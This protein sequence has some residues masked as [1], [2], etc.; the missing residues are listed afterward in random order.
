MILGMM[1][2]HAKSWLIKFLIGIIAVVFIFYFGYSFTAKQGLKVALV[3]GE[4]IS[5]LEYGK[6]YNDLLEGLRRQYKDI[7]SDNLI[8]V[9]DLKRRALDNL[10][11]QKL[12]S[13]EAR[14][15]GLDVTE[16][17]VQKAIMDYPAFQ[18]DGRFVMG[19]YKS[20]LSSNRMKPEDFEATMAQDLL[21][22]KVKQFLFSFMAATGQE[23]LDQY[24]YANEKISL[25]YVQFKPEDF[26]ASVKPDEAAVTKYFEENRER[27]RVPERVKVAYLKLDPDA[28]GDMVRITEEEI[29]GYYEYNLSKYMVPRRVRARHILFKLDQD[30]G[31]AEERAVRDEARKVLAMV[32]EGKDFAGLAKKYSECPSKEKGGDL[33]YFSEG[34]MVKPFEEAAFALEPGQISDLVRTR[35]GYHIIKVEDKKPAMTKP[36]E[37]VRAEIVASLTKSA[38]AELA[39]EKGLSLVDQMPYDADLAV[40]A[41]EQKLEARFTG[42]FSQDE[43]IPGIGGSETLRKSVF[44]LEKDE[45]SQLV[46]IEGKFYLMQVAERKASYLPKLEEV[47]EKVREDY[48]AHVA[49]EKAASAAKSCL[50][51]LKAG[52]SWD[53]LAKQKN[54]KTAKTGFFT[55][56]EP[57]P[58]IGNG[59]DLKEMVFRLQEARPYPEG[60]HANEKGAF[61]LRWNAYQGID[62]KK[63]QEEKEN[64]RLSLLQGK[65]RMVYM[66]WLENLRRNAE[67]EILSP[68]LDK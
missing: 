5:G 18:V 65:H 9:F 44:S 12:I 50:A 58:E 49:A 47:S 36:L 10:I 45:T 38:C 17:E 60:I 40:Y 27:Y 35:F 23:V 66:S 14:R 46:E 16:S 29:R 61:V 8:K 25:G 21:D 52:K 31:E 6:A 37:D 32:Q 11:N 34:Q 20:L 42:F 39:H 33:D 41:A 63:Y 13:S 68:V 53:E 1:R 19:R 48:I 3:N 64:Y 15:L 62:E 30:A 43:P 54:I 2:K 59:Q 28:F 26:K 24:T 22:S 55:R 4:V 56:Q 7:W 57:V 51:D 67:I